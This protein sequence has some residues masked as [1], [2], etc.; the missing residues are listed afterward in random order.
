MT[1]PSIWDD[2]TD[3][4]CYKTFLDLFDYPS[5]TVRLTFQFLIRFATE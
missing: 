4:N 1:L 2:M 5:L 3:N